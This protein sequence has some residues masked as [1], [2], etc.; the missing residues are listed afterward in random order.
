[1]IPDLN[2]TPWW[3]AGALVAFLLGLMVWFL[4]YRWRRDPARRRA[5]GGR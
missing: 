4:I 2:S 3:V 1:M 5:G